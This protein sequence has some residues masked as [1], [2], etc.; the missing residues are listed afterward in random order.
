MKVVAWLLG[1]A[2]LAGAGVYTALSVVRW[3][4]NRALF[5]GIVFL[6]A[7]IALATALL[8]QRLDKIG[9]AAGRSGP[10]ELEFVRAARRDH[11]RFEWLRNDQREVVNRSSVFITL[12][13]GS[14]VVLSG[15]AWVLDKLG[16]ATIDRGRE[17]RLAG[18][19]RGIRY[20]DG[21]LLVDESTALAGG[22]TDHDA[23]RMRAITGERR[24]R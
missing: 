9:S 17:E 18:D 12:L 1:V 7:Q 23:D 5:F 11:A 13:V 20:P 2:T 10:R 24:T 14:G 16:A 19:L 8:L 4:W 15:L 3:E 6:A 21:G 22:H